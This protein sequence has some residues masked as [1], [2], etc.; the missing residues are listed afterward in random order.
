[1][2][3]YCDCSDVLIS[4]VVSSH[5]FILL[6]SLEESHREAMEQ[7]KEE[8]T[9]LQAAVDEALADAATQA[10][11][12]LSAE[13]A[14]KQES[15][16]CNALAKE[17][18]VLKR[19]VKERGDLARRVIGEKDRE[20]EMLRAQH[21]KR[22]ANN[23]FTP[24]ESLIDQD[25]SSSRDSQSADGSVAPSAATA[26]VH[27]PPPPPSDPTVAA[28]ESEAITGALLAQARLQASR[29]SATKELKAQVEELMTKLKARDE[30]ISEK[31]TNAKAFRERINNLE[32]Y[33]NNKR[34][35]P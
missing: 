5:V 31:D 22:E 14:A 30:A 2:C 9:R 27:V 24:L 17:V 33:Y 16:K 20:L 6:R 7:H 21:K 3:L 1:V 11:S 34:E 35:R 10:E 29:E 13:A 23:N 8:V 12:L 32:K 25:E 4:F 19:S 26:P 18:E 15:E 28:R